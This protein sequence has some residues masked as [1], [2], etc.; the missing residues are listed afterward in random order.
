LIPYTV[1]SPL[2]SDGAAKSRWIALPTNAAV[3]FAAT[4]EWN[5]PT[6]TV[7]I[8]HFELSTNDVVPGQMKR[9]ETRLLVR[10]TNGTVYGA[11]YKWRPDYSDADLVTNAIN[12]AISVTT[13]SGTRTQQ[14][15]YPAPLD[16]LRCHTSAAGG[17][18]GVKTRQLN[19]NFNY[20]ST[21]VADNQLR[22]WNHA[23]MFS[24]AISEAAIPGY[25]SLVPVT[26]T[27]ASL[28]TRVRSYIDANCSHCHR[29]GSG[30]LANFDARFDTPFN[31]QGIVNG[32]VLDPLGITGARVVA[33]G[34][35]VKS[36]LYQR[37]SSLAAIQM[38]P[39]ARNTLDTNAL[40]A[41]SQWIVSLPPVA[42]PL[43]W[44]HT[45]IG[46]VG[47]PGDAM[48]SN[49]QFTVSGSG[50]DIWNNADAFHYVYRPLGGDGEIIAR[51]VSVQNT[52][53]WA[54]A[55][56]MIRE[57][58]AAGSRQAFALI[59]SAN[60]AAFQRRLS[61]GGASTHTAGAIVAAPYWVRLTR[62]GN[63]FTAYSSSNGVSWNL[64]GSDTIT[65][66]GKVFAGLAVTAHNNAALNTSV[67]DSVSGNFGTNLLPSVTFVQPTNNSTYF[68]PP[69]L[70][71]AAN[72]SDSDGSILQVQFLDG[73]NLLGTV[74]GAGPYTYNWSYPA[75]GI[76]SL[77]A[78]AVDD[79]G[80]TNISPTVNLLVNPLSLQV[81]S[82]PP[83]GGQFQ[84]MFQG[85]N[86]QN[87]IIE[88]S[89]DLYTWLPVFTNM[90][91][92]GLFHFTATNLTE[93]QRF[94][95]VRQ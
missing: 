74:S 2:W 46:S 16:C 11:T 1:N 47:V 29:P 91:L 95:R 76:H 71:L 5:F 72:A 84:L 57:S 17:V 39:L 77:T 27:S 45:D 41:I 93:A 51:V 75:F 31:A 79:W 54:K 44:A 20:T 32:S 86:G 6:G 38:P 9:L 42:F 89:V 60:G 53:P 67:L 64:I 28:E 10:D 18:L 23:G 81:V 69:V 12:E 62:A 94:Y 19:G 82:S 87:Y 4:G 48:V 61:T 90:P 7:F 55:G 35:L 8:K 22:A 52:D 36:I 50:A 40:S 80:A 25:A 59:S 24:N 43:P 34:D 56:V 49:S 83:G 85:Q 66:Q 15:Y 21:G 33:P 65:M 58:L 14:W 63:L 78:R 70:T 37:D 26:D 30:V 68:Q 3:N 92:N 73:A 13:A 88:S